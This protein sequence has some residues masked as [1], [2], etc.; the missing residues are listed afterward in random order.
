MKM[1]RTMIELAGFK[2]GSESIQMHVP[3]SD[4]CA[5]EEIE[6]NI[7]EVGKEEF[8]FAGD[9]NESTYSDFSIASSIF[10][11]EQDTFVE[12]MHDFDGIDSE[13]SLNSFVAATD[14]DC[15]FGELKFCEFLSCNLFIYEAKSLY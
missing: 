1:L 9:D 6:T 15:V 2:L 8:G 11:D 4:H 7:D 13:M 10:D 12:W 3:L 14:N 5:I